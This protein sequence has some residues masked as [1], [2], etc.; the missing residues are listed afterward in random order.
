MA[1][2][3]LFW[4]WNWNS[5]VLKNEEEIPSHFWCLSHTLCHA[6]RMN[7]DIMIMCLI[8]VKNSKRSLLDCRAVVREGWGGGGAEEALVPP[9]SGI[10]R[11]KREKTISPPGFENL[12][13][14]LGCV[15]LALWMLAKCLFGINAN[16]VELHE[17]Y[18]RTKVRNRTKG[19]LIS[20]WNFGV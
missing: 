8:K 4:R 20:E 17:L 19:Q 7:Y 5:L 3:H 18:F 14:A 12:T 13:T 9:T 11:L 2:F 10:W 6:Q 1:F 16:A 15:P